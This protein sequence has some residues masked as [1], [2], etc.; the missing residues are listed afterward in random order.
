LNSGKTNV[1]LK[2]PASQSDNY[3]EQSGLAGS[4]VDGDRLIHTTHTKGCDPWW[5][6]DL[7]S[8]HDVTDIVIFNRLE[9]QDRLSDFYVG[10]LRQVSGNWEVAAQIH[11]P[12]TATDRVGFN[13]EPAAKGQIVRIH[14]GG[15]EDRFIHVIQ[16]EVY[17]TPA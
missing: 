17:G 15:C 16:V 7:G 13:F 9:N 14:M 4:A 1:A 11:H 2:K 5:Q 10:V 8:V 12:K 6:V 3:A